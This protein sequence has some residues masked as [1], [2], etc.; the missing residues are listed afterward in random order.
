MLTVADTLRLIPYL[1]FYSRKYVVD[2]YATICFHPFCNSVATI[3]EEDWEKAEKDHNPE[4]ISS[5]QQQ[6]CNS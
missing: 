2:L 5:I 1:A 6:D 3:A 4:E